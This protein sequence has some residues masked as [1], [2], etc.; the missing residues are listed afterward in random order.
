MANSKERDGSYCLSWCPSRLHPAMLAVGCGRENC[1]RIYR[2]KDQNRKW[3]P[4][5][6]LP[7]PDVVHD[8]AWAPNIGRSFHL[9]ATACRDGIVRIWRVKDDVASE[10]VEF[11]DHQAEVWRVSW[12]VTGT[13]LASSG[14]DGKVRL[15]KGTMSVFWLA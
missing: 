5:V 7:H 12:N 9:I 6:T 11:N 10:P 13:V 3:M 8:V 1:V 4:A 15:Y 2:Y 14:D